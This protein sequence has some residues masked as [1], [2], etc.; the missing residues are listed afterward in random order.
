VTLHF[1]HARLPKNIFSDRFKFDFLSMR[2][3]HG[4]KT[5]NLLY[6]DHEMCN[7][8]KVISRQKSPIEAL[9]ELAQE[10]CVLSAVTKVTV[11]N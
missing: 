4:G 8:T 3:I 5:K 7:L 9:A 10:S 6:K 11:S 2:T 1:Q